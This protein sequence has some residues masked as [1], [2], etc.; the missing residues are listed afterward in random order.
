V[1]LI[2]RFHCI[3]S[4]L[5]GKEELEGNQC[6]IHVMELEPTMSR[7]D[8]TL[9]LIKEGIFQQES[10]PEST[11][12]APV[13]I[14]DDLSKVTISDVMVD[15]L[16][17]IDNRGSKCTFCLKSGKWCSWNSDTRLGAQ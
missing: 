7:L 3:Y 11:K 15:L 5:Q 16:T 2:E 13:L 17:L 10:V 9:S 8:F 6:S 14:L 1:T 4:P 12:Y